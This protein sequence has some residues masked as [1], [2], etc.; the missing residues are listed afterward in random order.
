MSA[1]A[2]L[3]WNFHESCRTNGRANLPPKSSDNLLIDN[4]S[5]RMR[6]FQNVLL[7]IITRDMDWS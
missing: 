1:C 3:G 7:S 4:C 2:E 5:T 6:A